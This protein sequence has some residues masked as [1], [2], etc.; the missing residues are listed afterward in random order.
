MMHT[1]FSLFFFDD[2]ILA[3]IAQNTNSYAPIQEAKLQAK[4][5]DPKRARTP[6]KDT[7][8][9]ELRAYLGILVYR[10]VHSEVDRSDY[11]TTNIKMA[12]HQHVSE[13]FARTRFDQL[14]T[15][16]HVAKP[17][18][19]TEPLRKV[20]KKK[21]TCFNKLEPLNT[22]LLNA[23]KCLWKPSSELAVD[24]FMVRFTGR[25]EKIVTIP[26][27]SIPT[28]IKGWSIAD[29]GYFLHWF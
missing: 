16:I 21:A 23:A 26:V 7:T 10:S 27:K 28:G 29:E 22:Q 2:C 8:V 24:E 14:E 13:I 1:V 3:T 17:N 5:P 19:T 4:N 6:W 20:L 25:I 18:A 12:N 11:W 15:T 9:A